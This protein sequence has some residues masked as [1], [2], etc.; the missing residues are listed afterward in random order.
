MHQKKTRSKFHGHGIEAIYIDPS[1][2]SSHRS[3][4]LLNRDTREVIV[5]RS[6]GVWNE[7]P[8]YDFLVSED[9]KPMIQFIEPLEA[10]KLIN[11]SDSTVP[12]LVDDISNSDSNSE[13]QRDGD[14]SSFL[15][16]DSNAYQWSPV[17]VKSLFRTKRN[18]VKRLISENHL[19]YDE[20]T[21]PPCLQFV[22]KVDGLSR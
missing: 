16:V 15:E 4:L 6:F 12:D 10:N 7:M 19:E 21:V 11:D 1:E 22:W 17:S 2:N 9:A 8:F 3:G 20:S 18:L 13:S 14:Q 5:R